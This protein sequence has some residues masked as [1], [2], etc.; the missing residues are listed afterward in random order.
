MSDGGGQSNESWTPAQSQEWGN[1]RDLLTRQIGTDGGL[2]DPNFAGGQETYAGWSPQQEQLFNRLTGEGGALESAIGGLESTLAPYDPNNPQLQ[3]VIDAAS[4]DITRN[5][6]ENILTSIGDAAGQAGQFGSTRHGI[7][8]GVAMRGATEDISDLASQLRFQDYGNWQANQQGAIANLG[9]LTSGLEY[10]AG[11]SQREQQAV[12]DD[13]FNRWQYE[14]SADL[15]ELT[16]I[17]DLLNVDMGG[18]GISSQQ[19]GK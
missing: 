11:G 6:Q 5:L 12:L 16:A 18:W 19:G 14:S 7:A 9:N 13:L 3:S 15:Q 2:V 10:A 4:G 17:R 1:Y 8:E